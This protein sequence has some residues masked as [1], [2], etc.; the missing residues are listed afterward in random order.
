MAHIDPTYA[1][2]FWS[3]YPNHGKIHSRVALD[4]HPIL[5]DMLAVLI[6]TKNKVS[7]ILDI[8]RVNQQGGEQ[9]LASSHHT[10]SSTASFPSVAECTLDRYSK[11]GASSKKLEEGTKLECFGCGGPHTWS[12]SVCRIYKIL[13]PN[14]NQP[15]V[16]DCAKLNIHDFQA[17]KKRHFKEFRKRKNVNTINREGILPQRREVILQQQ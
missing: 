14:A 8:V 7:N 1:K 10:A 3:N 9:F 12:K 11:D 4:Q 15:G 2:G 13:C 6:K 17:R 5:T 16:A